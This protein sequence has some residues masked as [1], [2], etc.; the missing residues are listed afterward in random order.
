MSEIT[1]LL[2]NLGLAYT[3]MNRDQFTEKFSE[4]VEK[5]QWDEEKM[6]N[7]ADLVFSQLNDYRQ[8]KNAEYTMGN[9][10]AHGNEA[11]VDQL[12][13]LTDELARLNAEIQQLKKP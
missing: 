4:L 5:Y 7:M 11:L 10:Y 1:R 3:L 8:R 6:R 13:T 2:F 9:A 12:K